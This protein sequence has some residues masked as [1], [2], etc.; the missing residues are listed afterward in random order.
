MAT[1]NEIFLVSAI[2]FAVVGS[3]SAVSKRKEVK[4]YTPCSPR[5]EIS[6]F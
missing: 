4:L 1:V 2:L 6:W 5:K 3:L